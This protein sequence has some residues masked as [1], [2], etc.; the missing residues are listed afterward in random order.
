MESSSVRLFHRQ[1][2]LHQILG[3]G[4]LADVILWRRRNAA[5]GI[6]SVTLAAWVVFER[7][8]YTLL[9]FVANVLLLLVSI[10]FVWAKSAAILNRPPPPLPELKIAEE[11]VQEVT[12]FVHTRLNSVLSVSQDIA[13]GKDSNLFFKVA[14]CL[15]VISVVGSLTDFLTLGYTTLLIVLTVPML[16]EKYEDHIDR[17]T[18]VAYTEARQLY[19]RLDEEV[20]SKVRKYILEKRKLS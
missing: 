1:R 20:L 2:S 8:G 10:L 3:G 4:T 5:L 18:M 15:W 17:Y 16:Y 12:A 19:A 9:S 6:L 11:V 7:S 13:L 14:G